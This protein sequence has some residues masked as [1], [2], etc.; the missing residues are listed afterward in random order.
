MQ[1]GQRSSREPSKRK[2]KLL[3][4][5]AVCT[6]AMLIADFWPTTTMLD[7][8]E[9]RTVDWRFH[10][11]GR[12]PPD[13]GIVLVT[14]DEESIKKVGKWPWPRRTLAHLTDNLAAA[15]ARA[16][17]Y[18]IF[19]VEREQDPEGEAA[20]VAALVGAGNVYLAGFGDATESVAAS[21]QDARGEP[22]A[23]AGTSAI[24]R[25]AWTQTR[26]VAGRGLG[27]WAGLCQLADLTYPFPELA[28]AARGIGY[29]ALV[30]AGD[31]VFRYTPPLAQYQGQIYPSLP[32]VA[33]A[34]L[35]GVTPAQISVRL[36]HSI[37]LGDRRRIPIDRWGR[38][39]VNFVGKEKTYP[40]LPAWR[41]LQSSDLETDVR[42]EGKTIVVAVTAQGLHDVRTSPFSNLVTGGEVQATILDNIV[43]QQFLVE[44][45]PER[46]LL[47]V[48]FIGLSIGVIFGILPTTHALVYSLGLLFAYNWLGVWAFVH[49]GVI[50][51]LFVPTVTGVITI[52]ALVSYRLLREES[53]RSQARETLSHFV[54]AQIASQLLEDEAAATLRGQRRV[55][56]V[57]F[58]DL[59]DFTAASERLSPDVTVTLLNRYFGLMHE[60]I[61]EFEGTL[62]K[63]IGDGL[64]AFFNAPVDQPDHAL[65]AVRTAIEMQRRIEFNRAEWEFCGWAELAAGI[66]IS[67]GEAIVGYVSSRER[68]QYT[69]IGAQVN[70]AA[71]LEELTKKLDTRILISDATYQLVRDAVTTE[72]KGHI[73]IHGFA[74]EVDVYSVAVPL[75]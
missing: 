5:A 39:V 30:Q 1:S 67:T 24:D 63:F 22:L 29:T 3:A 18:D 26:L 41:I 72:H 34:G 44:A 60:V 17:I 48:L 51:D 52:L 70:L 35:L 38:M 6:L 15:G 58:C 11:R 64:M 37:V 10:Y 9:L 14:V 20:F 28:G 61:W 57:L 66:G 74:E 19:F 62:D 33:A 12:L 23:S 40:H 4:V 73:P 8:M 2:V 49:R 75:H 45:L 36:G 46:M 69:A 21:G 32:V 50:V 65:R 27:S 54:P 68:M 7:R 71:R 56:S 31:G 59:R 13:P 43:N 25:Y 42:L 16:I 53:H 55:V 47:V